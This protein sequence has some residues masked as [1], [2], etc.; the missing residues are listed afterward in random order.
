MTEALIER[1]IA[2]TLLGVALAIFWLRIR[3]LQARDR[4]EAAEL[5]SSA[6][7]WAAEE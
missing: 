2:G 4:D 3:A 6:R 7:R 5:R 1:L